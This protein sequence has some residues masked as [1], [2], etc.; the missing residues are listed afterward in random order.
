MSAAAALADAGARVLVLEARPGLGG[1]ATSFT[2]PA[3]AERVDNGQHILMGC[4]E[5]T[6]DSCIGSAPPIACGGRA[7]FGADDRSRGLQSVLKLP[8]VAAPLHLLGGVMAWQALGWGER[9]G[10]SAGGVGRTS[11][12]ARLRWWREGP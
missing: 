9:L 5:Q 11:T 6:F 10:D 8:S 2:D 3:T 4:Y 7:G 1:R 12:S